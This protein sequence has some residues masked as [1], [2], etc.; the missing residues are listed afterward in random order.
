MTHGLTILESA[1]GP[2]PVKDASLSTI[3]LS[4]TATAAAGAPT[5]ALDAMFPMNTP[6]LVTDIDVLKIN[7]NK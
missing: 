3:G 2:R 6:V 7:N 4:V 5:A 1:T